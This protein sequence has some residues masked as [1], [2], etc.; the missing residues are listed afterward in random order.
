VIGDQNDGASRVRSLIPAGWFEQGQSPVLDAV[1][2]G[3]GWAISTAYDLLSFVKAQTRITT[4]TGGWLDLIAFDFFGRALRRKTGQSDAAYLVRIQSA[5]FRE[6]GT[7]AGMIKALTVLT[8]QAPF[9]FEPNRPADTGGYGV[10]CGY[11]MAGGYGAINRPY[12]AMV[13]VQRPSFGGNGGVAGYGTPIAGYGVGAG[14]YTAQS[15]YEDLITDQ[16][17]LDVINAV[18]PFGTRVWVNIG[19]TRPVSTPMTLGPPGTLD[20]S[21]PDQSGLIAAL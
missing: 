16:D 3:Y 13:I 6:Q 15:L 12:E 8:G 14:E 18:K 4:A 11:G 20:F 19:G 2:Q 10:A 5:L 7:R 21:D 1:L 9:I 17:I